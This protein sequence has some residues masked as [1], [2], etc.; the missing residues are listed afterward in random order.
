MRVRP[1]VLTALILALPAIA[2]AGAPPQDPPPPPPVP[3]F[4]WQPCAPGGHQVTVFSEG[5]AWNRGMKAAWLTVFN[6]TNEAQDVWVRVYVDGVEG[7]LPLH[8]EVGA[9]R[10]Y[11]WHLNAELLGLERPSEKKDFNFA[12][13][14]IFETVGVA[15]I[16]VW[17]LGSVGF[18]AYL[19]AAYLKGTDF[20]VTA[21]VP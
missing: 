14:V 19:R 8:K 21:T 1:L 20:C 18:P 13:E 12:T 9:H 4:T 15:N 2:L 10:R 6:P 17:E 7:P 11:A 5:T 3:T 16:A